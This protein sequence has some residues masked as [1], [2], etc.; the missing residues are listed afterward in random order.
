MLIM[1]TAGEDRSCLPFET[2]LIMLPLYANDSQIRSVAS[3][4]GGKPNRPA[5]RTCR[6]HR[7]R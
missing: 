4:G 3:Y 2:R 1:R 7:L 6:G 5:V